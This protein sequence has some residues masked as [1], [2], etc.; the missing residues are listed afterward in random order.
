MLKSEKKNFDKNRDY[1][2]LSYSSLLT[3]NSSIYKYATRLFEIF[4]NKTYMHAF[5]TELFDT[6]MQELS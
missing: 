3:N 2:S 5:M 4:I 6:N 1:V